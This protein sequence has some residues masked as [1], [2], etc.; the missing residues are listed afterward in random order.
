MTSKALDCTLDIFAFCQGNTVDDTLTDLGRQQA[1]AAARKH[2]SG[3][4]LYFGVSC[5]CDCTRDTLCEMANAI[6]EH[7][8]G[9][10]AR[11]YRT[12]LLSS[13]ASSVE[14]QTKQR[15]A[16][17]EVPKSFQDAPI[18]PVGTM[19]ET[20]PLYAKVASAWTMA[21]L[22]MI[23]ERAR[24][25]GVTSSGILAVGHSPGIQMAAS[26][27][28]RIHPPGVPSGVHYVVQIGDNGKA[29]VISSKEL[30]PPTS[31]EIARV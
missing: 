4:P 14:E 1:R 24:E 27:V 20:L 16:S 22:F 29:N 8:V 26:H 6:G 12:S 15:P 21:A 23:A 31:E 28:V 5:I 10:P 25:I 2:L 3:Q 19:S 18:I 7:T 11:V 30:E 9:A 13:H 17:E